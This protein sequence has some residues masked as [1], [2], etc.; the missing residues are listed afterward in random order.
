MYFC[1]NKGVTSHLWWMCGLAVQER[2]TLPVL[3]KH[4][5][6]TE[7]PQVPQNT[8]F[9][10]IQSDVPSHHK[11]SISL[12]QSPAED[13]KNQSCIVSRK[14]CHQLGP[15]GVR[16]VHPELDQPVHELVRQQEPMKLR[17][18]SYT[19]ATGVLQII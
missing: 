2:Y 6:I 14:I 12:Q 10:N 11:T 8:T 19:W 4:P 13:I 9:P 15:P 5:G 17:Q 3:L 16:Q 18:T 7:V 1:D